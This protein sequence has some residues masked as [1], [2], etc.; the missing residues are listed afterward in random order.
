MS[1][2]VLQENKISLVLNSLWLLCGSEVRLNNMILDWFPDRNNYTYGRWAQVSTVSLKFGGIQLLAQG[3]FSMIDACRWDGGL[4]P[5]EGPLGWRTVAYSLCHPA[6]HILCHLSFKSHLVEQFWKCSSAS[7]T[8]L[9]TC[10]PSGVCVNSTP[11]L[12]TI[13]GEPVH[14]CPIGLIIYIRVCIIH[15]QNRLSLSWVS[16]QMTYCF[17][18]LILC[19]QQ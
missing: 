10:F 14:F 9:F 11:L 4:N 16:C 18:L 12:S 7:I 8:G 13:Q 15:C 17:W 1:L 2:Y 5:A 3:H 6:V 19:P